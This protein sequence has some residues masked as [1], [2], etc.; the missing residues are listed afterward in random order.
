MLPAQSHAPSAIPE[1]SHTP[2]SST[3]ASPPHTSAQSNVLPAQSHA[4]SAI[5]EPA[6]TPHSSYTPR[7]SSA[8]VQIPSSSSSSHGRAE[9]VEL[10]VS[11]VV[12]RSLNAKASPS[13]SLTIRLL[14]QA[15]VAVEYSAIS[16]TVNKPEPAGI[17]PNSSSENET[18]KITDDPAVIV[19]PASPAA[20]P[21]APVAIASPKSNWK[22]AISLELE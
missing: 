3:T 1:P 17:I 18:P 9:H 16:N 20:P 15:V 11:A 13:V 10:P 19:K 7:Q 8:C 14:K 5:P 4:P 12:S 2:H 22:A 6:H 21:E